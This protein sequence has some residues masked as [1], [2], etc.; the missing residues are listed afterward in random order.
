MLRITVQNHSGV[1]IVLEG[2]LVSDWV[3]ELKACCQDILARSDP[4]DVWI[5][6]ADISFVDGAGTELLAEL[7]REGVHL[8]SD[9]VAMDAVVGDI[10][11]KSK[12]TTETQRHRDNP[13]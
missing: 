1:R 5:E 13:A 12:P 11:A 9:D 6:L 7:S 2:K 10:T 3:R 8:L 4:A